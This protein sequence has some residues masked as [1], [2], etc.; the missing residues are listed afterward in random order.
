MAERKVEWL[1]SIG[2]ELKGLEGFRRRV[3][4]L[5]AAHGVADLKRKEG[6]PELFATLVGGR[7]LR[8]SPELVGVNP[9]DMSTSSFL[10]DAVRRVREE[11]AFMDGLEV[12]CK[13]HVPDPSKNTQGTIH[14]SFVFATITDIPR[15][16]GTYQ[17]AYERARLA[18]ELGLP[19]EDPSQ[20]V[21]HTKSLLKAN[22]QQA[23]RLRPHIE[24]LGE[25]A[26]VTLGEIAL[27]DLPYSPS[28]SRIEGQTSTI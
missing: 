18:E 11:S 21:T 14:G 24:R 3:H 6:K 2:R 12:P 9:E 19:P 26:T 28:H 22:K 13:L 1:P 27:H 15:H 10:L 7:F 20:P 5:A 17:F 25:G 8:K 4:T 23:F 16:D